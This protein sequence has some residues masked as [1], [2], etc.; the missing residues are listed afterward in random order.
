MKQDLPLNP[1]F[2]REKNEAQKPY[3]S[4]PILISDLIKRH[5]PLPSSRK[6]PYALP[7]LR[8]ND[9]ALKQATIRVIDTDSFSGNP[10]I[11]YPR[12]AIDNVGM[13]V[14]GRI[15]VD[16]YILYGWIRA[17]EGITRTGREVAPAVSDRRCWCW[18]LWRAA[19]GGDGGSGGGRSRFH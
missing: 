2:Q 10:G 16:A 4:I 11:A 19:H 9:T 5:R 1:S 8:Q 17:Y 18:R 13:K 15:T 12:I 14:N 7:I 6:N 3:P